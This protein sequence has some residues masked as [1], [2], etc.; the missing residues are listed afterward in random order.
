M[1]TMNISHSSTNILPKFIHHISHRV[2]IFM[3]IGIGWLMP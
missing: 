3:G 1:T 2:V